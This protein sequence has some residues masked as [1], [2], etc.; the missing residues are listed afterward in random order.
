MK[1]KSDPCPTESYSQYDQSAGPGTSQIKEKILLAIVNT[2]FQKLCSEIMPCQVMPIVSRGVDRTLCIQQKQPLLA[3]STH[4]FPSFPFSSPLSF[5]FV[6]HLFHPLLLLA[7][8]NVYLFTEAIQSITHSLIYS[9]VLQP[10]LPGHDGLK[11]LRQNQSS[12][13]LAVFIRPQQHQSNRDGS[14]LSTL[15]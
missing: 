6:L 3:E 14:S 2:V 5:S 11:T 9:S 13:P 10:C 4:F 8:S 7:H 12:F 1:H 15:Q